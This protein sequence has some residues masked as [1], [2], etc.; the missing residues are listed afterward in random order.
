MKLSTTFWSEEVY[1]FNELLYINGKTQEV[2]FRTNLSNCVDTAQFFNTLAKFVKSKPVLNTAYTDNWYQFA[3]ID[4]GKIT[5]V[6]WFDLIISNDITISHD[7]AFETTLI[8]KNGQIIP[9]GKFPNWRKKAPSKYRE[10]NI[11][12]RAYRY[13]A[14]QIRKMDKSSFC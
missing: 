6:K 14:N 7:I 2:M 10:F 1:E 12:A 9:F 4:E 8:R 5:L 13:V 11:K 3:V